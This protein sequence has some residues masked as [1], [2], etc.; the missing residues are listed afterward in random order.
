MLSRSVVEKS[1]ANF[2]QVTRMK[3]LLSE[4]V[5]TKFDSKTPTTDRETEQRK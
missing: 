1:E 3:I 4:A 5:E 2:V